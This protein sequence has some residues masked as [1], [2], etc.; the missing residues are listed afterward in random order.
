MG[1]SSDG[2]ACRRSVDDGGEIPIY[3]LYEKDRPGRKTVWRQS[4]LKKRRG[5]RR[6]TTA[7]RRRR[8][9]EPSPTKRRPARSR[10][11]RALEDEVR[12]RRQTTT[13]TSTAAPRHR[14]PVPARSRPRPTISGVASRPSRLFVAEIIGTVFSL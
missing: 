13:K 1:I 4:S 10:L 12:W 9:V 11:R 6:A 8:P 14:R 3:A 7:E 5:R 2:V